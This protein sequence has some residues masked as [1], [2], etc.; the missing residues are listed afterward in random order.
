M[1][2]LNH[3]SGLTRSAPGLITF[4]FAYLHSIPSLTAP[5]QMPEPG[6]LF[7]LQQRRWLI[8]SVEEAPGLG[9]ATLVHAACADDDAQ[10]EQVAVLWEHELCRIS[11]IAVIANGGMSTSIVGKASK[12]TIAAL[13]LRPCAMTWASTS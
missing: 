11:S 3:I 9:Q 8:E 6:Q 12:N 5:C 4:G 7:H 13:L 2:V 10:G 1:F